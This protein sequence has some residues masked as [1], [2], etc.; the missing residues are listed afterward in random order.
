ML[1]GED[2]CGAVPQVC[3]INVV[4]ITYKHSLRPLSPRSHMIT[5]SVRRWQPGSA[6]TDSTFELA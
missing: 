4:L 5:Y 3:C 1:E 6:L 2:E